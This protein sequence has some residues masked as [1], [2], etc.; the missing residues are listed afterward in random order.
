MQLLAGQDIQMGDANYDNLVGSLNGLLMTMSGSKEEMQ[1]ILQGMGFE[2]E[3]ENVPVQSTDTD[4]RQDQIATV[5]DV[6]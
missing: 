6:P 3:L 2:A 1:R 4:N 5:E